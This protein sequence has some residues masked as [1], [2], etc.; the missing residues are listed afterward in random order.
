[1]EQFQNQNRYINVKFGRN[2]IVKMDKRKS[3]RAPSVSEVL[4]F[5]DFGD[6]NGIFDLPYY[7]NRY[8]PR[9]LKTRKLNDQVFKIKIITHT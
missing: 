3:K 1:M 4:E 9:S 2:N 7:Q 5:I 8:K 6:L